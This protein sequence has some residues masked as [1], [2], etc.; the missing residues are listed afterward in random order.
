M[1]NILIN[2]QIWGNL[3]N[4]APRHIGQ[5]ITRHMKMITIQSV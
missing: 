3:A 4:F 5:K 1:K 2:D